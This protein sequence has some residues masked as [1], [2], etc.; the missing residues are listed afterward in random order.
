M[1]IIKIPPCISSRKHSLFFLA[2]RMLVKCADKCVNHTR[3]KDVKA[4]ASGADLEHGIMEYRV[5]RNGGL[6][7]GPI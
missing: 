7:F 6:C 1:V 2:L 3:S 4:I 5:P